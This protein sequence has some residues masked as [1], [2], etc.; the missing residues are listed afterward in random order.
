MRPAHTIP[1]L[2]TVLITMN[3]NTSRAATSGFDKTQ[4]ARIDRAVAAGIEL[5]MTPGAVV[6]AGRSDGVVF[7]KA[8]GHMRYDPKSAP[9][10]VDTVFDLASLSK[11]IGCSTSAMILIDRGKMSPEDRASQY[12][13][14]MDR[15]DKKDITVAD[16]LLH[17]AGFMPDNPIKDF[18]DGT[19]HAM[20][21]I[22]EGKLRYKPGTDYEYSD[23][24]FIVLGEVVKHVA[25]Q[26]LDVFAHNNVFGPLK[27]TQKT[28]NPPAEWRDHIAP[29]EKRDGQWI[30][31]EVHDPRSYAF[32]GVAGHAGVFSSAPDV[33]RFCRM[34]LN[35]GELDG[36]RI[37]SE[38]TVAEW[39]KPRAVINDKGEKNVRTYGF[40]CDTKG[41]ASPRG[42]RFPK[43]AS[44]GHTGYTG[45]DL[46]IDPEDNAFVVDLSNRVHPDDD[47][48]IGTLRKR[49]A[50]I[51]AEAM[52]GPK[53]DAPAQ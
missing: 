43:G 26:P 5:E 47:A 36:V 17:H 25:G 52:L 18:N 13:P 39:T 1:I 20:E 14:G 29:T 51:V 37:M 2:L 53:G 28:Y 30:V 9:M 35:K 23:N 21:K 31:G 44:F 41:S 3:A 16:L 22:Y 15:P 7:Q 46:W 42:R 50:T 11:V 33:A 8:Y 32:G 45:T 24:S 34:V 38:K 27:M 12:L 40:D 10:T 48:E 49:V 19:E 4:E 6:I